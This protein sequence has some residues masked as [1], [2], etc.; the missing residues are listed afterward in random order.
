MGDCTHGTGT[1]KITLFDNHVVGC[2]SLSTSTN[3]DLSFSG[4][5]GTCDSSQVSFLDDNR[6]IYTASNGMAASPTNPIMGTVTVTE[7]A[8][9]ATCANALEIQ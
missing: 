6:T 9:G 8:A 7:L 2:H 4:G 5:P 3:G 1:S